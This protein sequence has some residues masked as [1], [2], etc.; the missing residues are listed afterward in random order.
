MT[1][2]QKWDWLMSRATPIETTPEQTNKLTGIIAVCLLSVCV[3][4]C[5]VHAIVVGV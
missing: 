4:M 3:V 1:E 5:L 2:D